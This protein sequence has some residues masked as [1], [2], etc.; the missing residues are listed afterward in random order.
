MLPVVCVFFSLRFYF[1]GKWIWNRLKWMLHIRLNTFVGW[2]VCLLICLFVVVFFDGDYNLPCH[3]EQ[4]HSHHVYIHE[5]EREKPIY[6]FAKS[7]VWHQDHNKCQHHVNHLVGILRCA[8]DRTTVYQTPVHFIERKQK[9]NN[10][11][12]R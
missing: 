9:N 11:K 7:C 3:C 5:I 12:K 4:F 6:F 1:W 2:A 10:E 8:V